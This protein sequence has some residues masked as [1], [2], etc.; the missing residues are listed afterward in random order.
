[1][2]QEH[3]THLKFGMD[4]KREIKFEYGFDSVNGVVKKVYALS[5]IPNIKD[6]CDVW[7]VL[8]LLYVRQFTGLKDSGGEGRDVL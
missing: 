3:N 7:G 8:P 6:K 1:M 4:N 5:E 2:N